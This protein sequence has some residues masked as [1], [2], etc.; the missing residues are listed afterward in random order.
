MDSAQIK[1][2]NHG[3][4]ERQALAQVGNI[5]LPDTAFCEADA[6]W[7][8]PTRQIKTFH[9]RMRGMMENRDTIIKEMGHY[10]QI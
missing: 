7:W 8:T 2:K 4:A 3:E 1:S 5:T 6:S 10:G 9:R